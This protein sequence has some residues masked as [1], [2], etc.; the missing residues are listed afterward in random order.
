MN[1]LDFVVIGAG[2]L[3]ALALLLTAP[4]MFQWDEFMDENPVVAFPLMIGGILAVMGGFAAAFTFV[5][6]LSTGIALALI[7]ATLV[8]LVMFS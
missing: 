2:A 8:W 7:I 3:V 5:G 4:L 1:G 6:I